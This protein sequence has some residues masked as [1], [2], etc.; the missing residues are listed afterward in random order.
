MSFHFFIF[1][2]HILFHFL[3]FVWLFFSASLS[4][5]SYDEY[6]MMDELGNREVHLDDCLP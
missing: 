5:V 6:V 2:S 3:I 4:Y 1:F